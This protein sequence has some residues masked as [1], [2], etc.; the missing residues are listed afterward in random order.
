VAA[1]KRIVLTL[2]RTPPTIEVLNT[3]SDKED[4]VTITLQL[5]EPGAAYCGAWPDKEATPSADGVA[6][7]PSSEEIVAQGFNKTEGIFSNVP[8]EIVISGLTRDTEYDTY[9]TAHDNAGSHPHAQRIDNWVIPSQIQQT[10]RDIHTEYDTTPPVVVTLSPKP[11]SFQSADIGCVPDGVALGCMLTVTLSFNEDVQRGV[12]NVSILC[13]N[14][15]VS[16]CEDVFV[17]MESPT[18]DGGTTFIENTRLNVILT[19][20]LVDVSTYKVTVS[21]GAVTDTRGNAFSLDVNCDP[22]F[23]PQ[24]QSLV[25]PCDPVFW[26]TTPS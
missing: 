14:A 26:F 21:E 8:F 5:D 13:N 9:C 25:K 18:F 11:G 24:W 15:G 2:D 6:K 4:A 22:W 23:K 17:P 12:G 1:T 16:L 10:K 19:T 7:L 3:S 20:P